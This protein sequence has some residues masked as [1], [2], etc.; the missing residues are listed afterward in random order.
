ATA[1]QPIASLSMAER[2]WIVGA[3][4]GDIGGLESLHTQLMEKLEIG[5]QLIYCGNMIGYLPNTLL[6]IENILAFRR[7]FLARPPLAHP[8]DIILLHGHQEE[9][10]IKLLI[11]HR[12]PDL[13]K[14]VRFMQERGIAAMIRGFGG[15]DVSFLRAAQQ[16]SQAMEEWARGFRRIFK[17]KS[18]HIAPFLTHMYFA[19][20]TPRD[21]MLIVSS[22]L[23]PHCDLAE[24]SDHFW[25]DVAG[26]QDMFA[27]YKN[28]TRIISGYSANG[29]GIRDEG[30]KLYLDGGAGRGGSVL[31]AALDRD[32]TVIEW[33]EG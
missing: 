30:F 33:L 24:Q 12:A 22:G 13:P 14:L 3:I 18:A 8:Q 9:M 11:I 2:V 19:A 17:H 4:H 25:W 20:R 10:L 27:P 7:W 6:V 23:S 5:D 31:A 28:F 29:F 16:G 32:G 15:D 21:R 1:A 26:L